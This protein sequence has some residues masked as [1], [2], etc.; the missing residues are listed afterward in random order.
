MRTT[1]ASVSAGIWRTDSWLGTSDPSPRTCRN[2]GPR[3]TVSVQTVPRSTVGAAGFSRITATDTVATARTTTVP[4]IACR[5]RFRVLSSGRAISIRLHGGNSEAVVLHTVTI[6]KHWWILQKV[7]TRREVA[8]SE[9]GRECPRT[10]SAACIILSRGRA[11][12]NDEA[13]AWNSRKISSHARTPSYLI[14]APAC[15]RYI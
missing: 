12:P 9:T 2:I 5:R 10:D 1:V 6:Y 4:M 3:F 8:L 7:H 15:N 11:S 14:I 13:A